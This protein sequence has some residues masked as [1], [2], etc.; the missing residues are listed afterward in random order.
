MRTVDVS[1][2]RRLVQL[3]ASETHR[4]FSHANKT[5]VELKLAHFQ[6]SRTTLNDAAHRVACMVHDYSHIPAYS[7]VQ[8][9]HNLHSHNVA[10]HIGQLLSNLT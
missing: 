2:A 8:R 10:F 3:I 9:Q 4:R 5:R 7:H 6:T 1:V